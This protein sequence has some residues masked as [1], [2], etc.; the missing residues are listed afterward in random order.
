MGACGKGQGRGRR[1][2]GQMWLLQRL[3]FIVNAVLFWK[4]GVES[5]LIV[6]KIKLMVGNEFPIT[7][8]SFVNISTFIKILKT[9]LFQT[10][11]PPSLVLIIAFARPIL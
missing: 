1:G 3:V 7:L 5:F 6:P 9:Y 2:E 10:A 11:F 8:K 4:V